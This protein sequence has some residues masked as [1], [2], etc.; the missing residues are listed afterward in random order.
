MGDENHYQEVGLDDKAVLLKTTQI[1]AVFLDFVKRQEDNRT[2][3]LLGGRPSIC[4]ISSC[5]NTPLSRLQSYLMQ[6]TYA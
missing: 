6:E 1:K 3:Q 5:K 2:V 4:K